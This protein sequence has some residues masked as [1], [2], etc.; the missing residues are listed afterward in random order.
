MAEDCGVLAL[1]V[2]GGDSSPR[3]RAKGAEVR[4]RDCRGGQWPSGDR[5]QNIDVW[6]EFCGRCGAGIAAQGG[7]KFGVLW[8]RGA[9]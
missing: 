1:S 2:T 6:G 3:G 7:V 5:V 9:A 4:A 8:G